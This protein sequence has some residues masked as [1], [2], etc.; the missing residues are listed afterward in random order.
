M[1]R[2]M[3]VEAKG[4]VTHIVEALWGIKLLKSDPKAQIYS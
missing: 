2:Q 1:R 3:V 4:G